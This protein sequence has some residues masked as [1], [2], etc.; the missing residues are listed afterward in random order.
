M[1]GYQE[2]FSCDRCGAFGA[3]LLSRNT[4]TAWENG[5]VTSEPAQTMSLFLSYAH[6]VFLHREC[7]FSGT[8]IGKEKPE[9]TEA[10]CI[11]GRCLYHRLIMES[12]W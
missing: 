3:D 10:P 11:T 6:E 2:L 1:L 12:R 8:Q 5:M 7:S 9:V 4:H